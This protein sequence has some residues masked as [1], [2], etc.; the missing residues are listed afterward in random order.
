MKILV[1]TNMFPGHNHDVP[2]QGVFVAEQ[3]DSLRARGL[4][5]DL[6][7][8]E[9]HKGKLFYLF[10]LLRIYSHI[11]LH[12]YDVIHVHYGLSGL[13]M[14]L[15]PFRRVWRRVVITLHGGDILPGQGKYVQVFLTK[16]IVSKAGV[17]ITLN[18]EMNEQV[19]SIN[20]SV[21]KIPCGVC[22]ELFT[23]HKCLRENIIV[24]PG[25]VNRWVKNYPFF[26]SVFE[27]YSLISQDASIVILD[28]MT[29]EQVSQLLSRASAL[30][31]TSHSEGSPQI[32]KEAMLCDVA[33]VSSDVGD[34]K[35]IIDGIKGCAVY[36]LHA[37][38]RDVAEQ[39]FLAIEASRISQGVRRQRIFE[40]HLDQTSVIDQL[41]S[42]YTD[43]KAA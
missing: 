34:V 1:I 3:V 30:L 13:F 14:L 25:A 22:P 32:V 20:T 28:G 8:I 42:L 7:V 4:D 26:E 21:V 43:I 12:K 29:R 39:L 23:P 27:Q 11:F 15:L 37:A 33:V 41:L 17:V 31:M 36:E 10:S 40:L 2:Y 35:D 38:P 5:C 9:G 24:F 16:L 6:I 18:E 19:R